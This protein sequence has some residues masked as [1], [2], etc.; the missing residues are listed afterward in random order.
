MTVLMG[1]AGIT[2]LPNRDYYIKDDPKLAATRAEYPQWLEKLFT[3]LDRPN[4][5]SDAAAVLALETGVA[6]AQWPQ[7]ETRDLRKAYNKYTLARL[8]QEMP[9]FDWVAWAGAQ[10]L[11][12]VP[13][14][15][16]AQPSFFK[17]YANLAATTPFPCGKRG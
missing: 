2:L 7:A 13:E 10:N 14:V 4:A 6:K 1:Q 9:G 3:L 5:A 11:G 17:T 15:I 16:V 8:A 12:R